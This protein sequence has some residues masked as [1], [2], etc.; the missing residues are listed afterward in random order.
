MTETE[1]IVRIFHESWDLRDPDRGATVIAEDCHFEDIAR[2]E[3]LPGPEAYK[4]DYYRWREAFPDGE[5]K[6]VNVIVQGN[7]AV[8]EFVNRGTHTGPLQSSLGT[9]EPTGRKVEV[10]YCSVM[11]VDDGKVVE[12]RD[13]YDSATIA[14]QLGLIDK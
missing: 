12:G 9:F 11:R 7:W 13:Y 10:R 14:R 6:V 1:R 5:C 8:V 4:R 2:S 3:L